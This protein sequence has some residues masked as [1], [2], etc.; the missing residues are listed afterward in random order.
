MQLISF[1]RDGRIRP[2]AIREV[3][4]APSATAVLDLNAAD[5]RLPADMLELLRGG[6]ETLNLA[7]HVVES[8]ARLASGCHS[9]ARS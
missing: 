7:R 2:G 6:E 3:L 9:T 1:S 4:T 5:E 8:A